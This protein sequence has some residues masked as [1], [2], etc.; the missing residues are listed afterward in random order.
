MSKTTRALA[1]AAAGVA[2]AGAVATAPAMAAGNS[3]TVIV[4]GTQ[5]SEAQVHNLAGQNK[6]FVV[7]GT[8]GKPSIGFTD[9]VKFN[10][11]VHKHLGLDMSKVGKKGA[12]NKA[13]ASW[14]GDSADLYTDANGFGSRLTIAS[15]SGVPDLNSVNCFLWWCSNFNDQIS[16]VYSHG[17]STIL[18]SETNYRGSIVI[19]PPNQHYNVPW[20]FNDYASSAWVNWSW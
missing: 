15:G 6:L 4:N 2:L 11:Y 10:A 17:V 19:A 12:S 5:R 14:S 7:A 18:Y 13:K 16:S 3:S 8:K 1:A 9:R 20:Y